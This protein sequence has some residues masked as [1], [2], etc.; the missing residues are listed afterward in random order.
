LLRTCRRCSGMG[1]CTD[2]API[3]EAF[4]TQMAQGVDKYKNQPS[5]RAVRSLLTRLVCRAIMIIPD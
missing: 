3:D 1:F 5:N 2:R 4:I